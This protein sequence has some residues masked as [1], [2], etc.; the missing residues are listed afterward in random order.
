MESYKCNYLKSIFAVLSF[1]AFFSLYGDTDERKQTNLTSDLFSL[2]SLEIQTTAPVIDGDGS[3]SIWE[4]ISEYML[5]L[6][7][8]DQKIQLVVKSCRIGGRTFFM[9]RTSLKELVNVHKVW[10]WD[11][12]KK[13]YVS[14]NE[15]ETSLTLFF[16]KDAKC[17][18]SA[19]VWAW[20]AARNN[21]SGFA[22]DMFFSDSRY[23][24]DKGQSS[25]YSRFFGE[26]AGATL[27]RF[28]QRA[29]N[30]SAADVRAKGKVKDG[31]LTVEFSR[32]IESGHSD[33]L[34]LNKK[35]F[36]KISFQPGVK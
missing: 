27:P 28:Y 18:D 35:L 1:L 31:I 16:Y 34:P 2:P 17:A 9:I 3:D 23:V 26:F 5:P 36:M 20:R 33:D 21:V 15:E 32:N 25:W 22:D 12:A 7:A 4:G 30:G 10:H 14:G 24:M 13:I 29:P 8:K 6:N 19:D 11:D